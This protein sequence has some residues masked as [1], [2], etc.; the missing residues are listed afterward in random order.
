MKH[1]WKTDSK[2]E[3]L[4]TDE[5]SDHP[6]ASCAICGTV[7]SCLNSQDP[8]Y[9]CWADDEGPKLDADDC[10]GVDLTVAVGFMIYHPGAAKGAD[11]RCSVGQRQL[12]TVELIVDAHSDPIESAIAELAL[13]A[14]AQWRIAKAAH[15]ESWERAIASSRAEP[16]ES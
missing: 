9:R 10:K 15:H 5:D 14:V 6:R 4:P 1:Q 7:S 13:A 11:D 2:G 8:G 3:P 12:V 16:V